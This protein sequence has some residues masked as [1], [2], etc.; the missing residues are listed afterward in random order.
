MRGIL[1]V[2][3]AEKARPVRAVISSLTGVR[4]TTRLRS[5]P[6][7]KTH[8]TA[9]ERTNK[10]PSQSSKTLYLFR[11]GTRGKEHHHRSNTPPQSAKS[12]EVKEGGSMSRGEHPEKSITKTSPFGLV[13]VFREI[14]EFK[15]KRVY[16]RSFFI[17]TSE[18]DAI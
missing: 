14:I 10:S 13:F 6:K 8:L 7:I 15:F 12:R 2:R 18:S 16:L 5:H 1:Y 3:F 17:E 4:G 11:S 9:A